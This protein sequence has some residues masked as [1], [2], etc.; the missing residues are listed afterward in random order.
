MPEPQSLIAT[1]VT[2]EVEENLRRELRRSAHEQAALQAVARIGVDELDTA[3]LSAR[4][5]P[6][7][8]RLLSSERVLI[9]LTRDE[10]VQFAHGFS[11]GS[12]VPLDLH[13]APGQDVAGWVLKNRRPYLAL[14]PEHDPVVSPAHRSRFACRSILAVPMLNHQS[15]VSGVVEF[16]N[17]RGPS[18][19]SEH[20][21]A[22]AQALVL[23]MTV[24][25]ERAV[26]MEGMARWSSALGNLFVMNAAIN[27]ALDPEALLRKLVEHAA[28]FLG[29]QAG[30]AGLL[31]SEPEPARLVANGFWHKQGWRPYAAAW[32]RDEGLA[33]WVWSY[34]C[35][36]L[37]NTYRDDP[38][39]DARLRADYDLRN[40]VCVPILGA[41]EQVLGFFQVLNKGDGRQPFTWSDVEFLQSLANVAGVAIYNARLLAELETQRGQFQALSAQ[42]VELL[43]EERRRISLELH[44]EAGQ[45]LIGVKLALQALARKAGQQNIELQADI[46]E[47]NQEVNGA[48]RRLQTLATALRPPALDQL[49]LK[50]ALSALVNDFAERAGLDAAIAAADERTDHERRLP[51]AVELALYRIVQEALTNVGRHAAAGRVS[52]DVMISD[53]RATVTVTDDGQGFDRQHLTRKTLGLLGMQERATTLGGVVDIVSSP[54]AGTR[55]IVNIPLASTS[56]KGS[57]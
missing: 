26:L 35:P 3:Q 39:A 42:Y 7:L 47:V 28:G 23:Q 27:R 24:A 2:T 17:R 19:F 10:A 48:A 57:T 41:N 30:F 56:G 34:E 31:R 45:A 5:A 52:V 11:D 25:F 1:P 36:Y 32:A 13:Y 38:L 22:F 21:V 29:A 20:D 53:A 37:T 8:A 44:D 50:A 55:V 9:G 51:T 4:L 14:D 33:G 46:Q 49:G 43:E 6:Q 54:G 16:H 15:R 40:A 12:I 18:P